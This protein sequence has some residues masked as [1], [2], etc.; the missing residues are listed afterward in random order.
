MIDGLLVTSEL[1]APAEDLV[2]FFNRPGGS[3]CAWIYDS[4]HLPAGQ[5]DRVEFARLPPLGDL[6]LFARWVQTPGRKDLTPWA[7]QF[8][9]VLWCGKTDQS[10]PPAR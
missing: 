9:D 5:T 6:A 2:V 4:H 3:R 1:F 10:R 8:G 7:A